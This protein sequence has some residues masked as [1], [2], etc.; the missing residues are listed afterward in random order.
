VIGPEWGQ[1]ASPESIEEA[2]ATQPTEA[3]GC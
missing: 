1:L 2:L 3:A